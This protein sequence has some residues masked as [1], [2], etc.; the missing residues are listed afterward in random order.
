MGAED[1]EL[2]GWAELRAWQDDDHSGMYVRQLRAAHEAGDRPRVRD[3][4]RRLLTDVPADL[5]AA[6]R[7]LRRLRDVG[8]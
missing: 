5:T 4:A 7:L 6:R 2:A 1:Q 3:L 8:V